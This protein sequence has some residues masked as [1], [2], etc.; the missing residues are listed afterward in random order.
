MT[1]EL[2]PWSTET[3][4]GGRRACNGPGAAGTAASDAGAAETESLETSGAGAAAGIGA[5]EGAAAGASSAIGMMETAFVVGA[6]AT[7]LADLDCT[8]GETRPPGEEACRDSTPF[9]I[10]G[11][12]APEKRNK[13]C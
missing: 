5:P 4:G 13:S 3:R 11:A 9:R 8:G 2:V 12:C 6:S 1:S 7:Y 10:S